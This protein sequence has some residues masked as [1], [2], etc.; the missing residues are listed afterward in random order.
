MKRLVLIVTAVLVLGMIGC[1]PTKA[2]TFTTSPTPANI[3]VTDISVE[4]IAIQTKQSVDIT[5]TVTNTGGTAGVYQ[6]VLKI[7]GVKYAEE[8]MTIAAGS[9]ETASYSATINE[10][11]GYT[12]AVG[13]SLAVF[14]VT[15]PEYKAPTYNPPVQYSQREYYLRQAEHYQRMANSAMDSANMWLWSANMALD[16]GDMDGYRLNMKWYQ[17]DMEDY[18]RYQKKVTEYMIKAQREP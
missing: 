13:E 5:V 11:G 16:R 2:P 8:S 3:S 18:A 15:A 6:L 1:A 14:I 10:A 4:P 7:N 17:W 9:T 12:V